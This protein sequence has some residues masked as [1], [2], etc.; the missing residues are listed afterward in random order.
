MLE[1]GKGGKGASV[2]R[3]LIALPHAVL[4]QPGAVFLVGALDVVGEPVVQEAAAERVNEFET[5][6][7]R[8]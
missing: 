2:K 1:G 5:G 6:G 8:V 7:V 4:I 3:D